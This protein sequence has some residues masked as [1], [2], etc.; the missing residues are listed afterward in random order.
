MLMF[1]AS[2]AGS[3]KPMSEEFGG[4]LDRGTGRTVVAPAS[5]GRTP[6]SLSRTAPVTNTASPGHRAP[7]RFQVRLPRFMITRDV[8]LG[9]VVKKGTSSVGIQPCSACRKR[10]RTLNRL[11]R[12]TSRST[13]RSYRSS[14]FNLGSS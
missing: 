12:F 2:E 14:L 6:G 4:S 13:G 11:L 9:D 10:A 5:P 3:N 1:I 7:P 8:G